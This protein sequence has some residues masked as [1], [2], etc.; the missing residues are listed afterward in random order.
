M[1]RSCGLKL[2]RQYGVSNV[3]VMHRLADLLTAGADGSEQVKLAEGLLFGYT[4]SC[5]LRAAPD[6][7]D[8]IADL[9]GLSRHE[10]GELANLDPGVALWKSAARVTS[11]AIASASSNVRS[12]IPMGG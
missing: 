1:G 6:A 11:S 9:L 12:L 8:A 5:D 10:A 2:A 7:I 3:L 4:D